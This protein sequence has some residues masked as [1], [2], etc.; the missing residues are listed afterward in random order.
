MHSLS[1]ID[2]VTDADNEA[3]GITSQCTFPQDSLNEKNL[4]SEFKRFT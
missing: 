2:F 1:D 4:H 3:K